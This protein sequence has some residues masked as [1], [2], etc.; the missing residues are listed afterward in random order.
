M[1]RVIM[2]VRLTGG[3]EC[4]ASLRSVIAALP[5]APQ[6]LA[7]A[8]AERP[9]IFA[10]MP[11]DERQVIAD[12]PNGGSIFADEPPTRLAGEAVF[13]L[14]PNEWYLGLC[15]ALAAQLDGD[16]AF[17]HGWPILSLDAGRS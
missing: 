9:S 13:K 7:R 6:V 4:S 11:G 8:V 17:R 2:D 10:D 16:I 1:A 12:G 3:Q 5:L 15:A 14:K